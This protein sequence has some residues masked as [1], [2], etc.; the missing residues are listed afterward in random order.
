MVTDPTYGPHTQRTRGAR[1]AT[2]LHVHWFRWYGE[3]PY[4]NGS[5][6]RCRCGVVRPGF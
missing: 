4:G 2:R 1:L 3:D 6:F 5:L